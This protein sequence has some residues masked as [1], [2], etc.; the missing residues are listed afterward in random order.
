MFLVP[1]LGIKE[2]YVGD[3]RAFS[4]A[5]GIFLISWFLLTVLFLVAALRTNIAI[6]AVLGCL[7]IAFLLL[8]V[9]QF[10]L[11]THPTAA[12]RVNR[13]GGAFAI[14]CALLAFYAGG[15]GIMREET[16][17]VRFPL[18]ELVVQK[19]EKRG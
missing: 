11:T 13:A 1:S 2:A 5:Q 16:T 18:G 9:A 6:L 10:I 7:A 17:W 19:T 8:S 14:I 3:A 12:V 4:V 15:A